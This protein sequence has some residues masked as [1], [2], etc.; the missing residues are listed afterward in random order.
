MPALRTYR[1]FISHCWEYDWHY[2]RLVEFLREEPLLRW[3]NFSV[4]EDQALPEDKRLEYHLRKRVGESDVLLVVVGMEVPQRHW[5][6]WELKWAHIRRTP[7]VGVMPNGML[8][9]P[10]AINRVACDIVGWRRT[11]VVRAIR[12]WAVPRR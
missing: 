10:A 4:P 12:E 3:T 6:K 7:V 1:V 9:V 2:H 8:R 5:V 11:S